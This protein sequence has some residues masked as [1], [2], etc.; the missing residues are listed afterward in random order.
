MSQLLLFCKDGHESN[1][2]TNKFQILKKSQDLI[3]F[4]V[5]TVECQLLVETKNV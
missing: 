4:Y 5:N 2:S 3:F 1:I